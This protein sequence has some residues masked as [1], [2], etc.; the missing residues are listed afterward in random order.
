[1]LV[2]YSWLHDVIEHNKVASFNTKSGHEASQALRPFCELGDSSRWMESEDDD[3]ILIC[4][5]FKV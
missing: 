1:M 3:Q 5:E 2:S 4:V